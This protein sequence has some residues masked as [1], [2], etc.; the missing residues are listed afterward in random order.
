[1][2]T[3]EGAG[4]EHTAFGNVCDGGGYWPQA[5]ANGTPADGRLTT[6]ERSAHSGEL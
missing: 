4:I 6:S 2:A 5:E 3:R 1:M